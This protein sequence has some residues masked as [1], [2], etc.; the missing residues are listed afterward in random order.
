MGRVRYTKSLRDF[1][2]AEEAD[3]AAL[4]S[5]VRSIRCVYETDAEAAQAVVPKPLEANVGSEVVVHFGSVVM[6]VSPDVTLEICS[7][8]FGVRVDYDGV[9]GC[10]LI[11]MPMSSE[12]AVVG[13]RERFGEPKKLADLEFEVDPDRRAVSASATRMGIRYLA[14]IGEGVEE[15]APR[16]ETEYA[17][18]FK[19][20]PSCD[21]SK[22]F[23]QDPQLVRLEWRHRHERLWR[24]RGGLELVESP[25]DP[26]ADLPVRRI[27]EF[28]YSEGSTLSSGRVLRPVPGDWLLPFLH[29]RYDAPLV[30]GVDV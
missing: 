14:A 18:C 6:H 13:G 10:Y 22:G 11:T 5:S 3:G 12:Q 1:E 19:A 15:L 24:L 16:E 21:P 8:S 29:Q 25:Y 7:A 4:N 23:D 26:V 9:P 17:Y 2:R 20:F 28:E 27:A 30:E